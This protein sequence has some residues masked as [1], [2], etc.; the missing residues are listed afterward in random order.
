MTKI[1]MRE[2]I[3]VIGI[4]VLFT[5]VSMW[6]LPSGCD[7]MYIHFFPLGLAL[8]FLTFFNV[9]SNQVEWSLFFSGWAIYAMVTIWLLK[10]KSRSGFYKIFLLFC[11]LLII[12][13]AGCQTKGTI[14]GPGD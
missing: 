8:P 14:Y 11:G 1:G 3:R 7:L 5:V 13:I 10:Q 12:N 9:S 2:K 4:A 6:V